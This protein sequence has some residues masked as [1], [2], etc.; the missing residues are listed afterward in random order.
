MGNPPWD[1]LPSLPGTHPPTLG[2]LF[3]VLAS[4]SWSPTSVYLRHPRGRLGCRGFVCEGGSS[5]ARAEL[6]GLWSRT[7]PA[8]DCPP[9]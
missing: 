4:H 6:Y 2:W 9:G 5:G 8:A 3:Q 1:I 7:G